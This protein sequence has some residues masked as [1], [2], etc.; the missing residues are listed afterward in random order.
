MHIKKYKLSLEIEITERV[1][2]VSHM[3]WFK[4]K[5]VIEKVISDI[6]V[7]IRWGPFS[8]ISFVTFT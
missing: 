2:R 1:Y 3:S 8:S 4:T 7:H 5:E 6:K